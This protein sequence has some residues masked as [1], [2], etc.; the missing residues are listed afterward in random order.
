VLS[1]ASAQFHR[2]PAAAQSASAAFDYFVLSLS[3]S[4]EFCAQP[5][6]A[7][8]NPAECARRPKSDGSPFVVHGLWPE[9]ASGRSPE[10]C[11]PAKAVSRLIVSETLPYMPSRSL[12]QHE[13]ATHG[14]CSGLTQADYFTA[15]LE[16][17]SAV[18]IP[19]Q[20]TSMEEAIQ[21]TP[22]QIEAQFAA[23]NPAFPRDAFR[24]ACRNRALT[25][26]RVCFDKS[27]KGRACTASAG[28]CDAGTVS[29][30]PPQ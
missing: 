20:L 6:A 14:T 24:V 3:W 25:E 19:V 11:G 16:T 12:M 28:E 29:V 13:W 30:R 1:V 9:A 21:E 22:E 7:A 17:R 23:S 10:S 26:V 27:L 2:K 15:I 18:Q 5:G 4:P 8:S